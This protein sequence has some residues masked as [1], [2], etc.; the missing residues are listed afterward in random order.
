VFNV[1]SLGE[2]DTEQDDPYLEPDYEPYYPQEREIDR[3]LYEEDYLKY[4]DAILNT[5]NMVFDNNAR[6]LV[7][8]KGLNLLNL[9][10]ED[11]G[12]YPDSSVGP[13]ISDMTI[14]IGLEDPVTDYFELFLMPIIRFPNYKDLTTDLDPLEFTLLV[15]NE[16]DETLKRV[17]LY[18]FL[19]T[20]LD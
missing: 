17:S 15:G 18:E 7:I 4:R 13:N 5:K 20:P 6:E 8:K 12:R 10:W 2:N 11:T 19:K 9:T 16:D 3:S 1:F 14:Q